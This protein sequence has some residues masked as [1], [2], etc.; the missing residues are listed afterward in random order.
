LTELSAVNFWE[1][2]VL[3]QSRV[4]PPGTFIGVKLRPASFYH[5]SWKDM[6]ERRRGGK[7]LLGRE[8]YQTS[9]TNPM[10]AIQGHLVSVR[11]VKP[12]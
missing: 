3:S 5:I 4:A 2:R 1:D 7:K 6:G 8:K 11:F 10:Q 12:K 9:P